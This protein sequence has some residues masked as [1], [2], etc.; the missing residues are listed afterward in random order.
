MWCLENRKL[1]SKAC[2]PRGRGSHQE[3]NLSPPSSSEPQRVPVIGQRPMCFCSEG[4]CLKSILHLRCMVDKGEPQE[5][6]SRVGGTGLGFDQ[7]QREE[8]P[9]LT[10]SPPEIT[11]L[12]GHPWR[13]SSLAVAFKPGLD[14]K[15]SFPLCS[16]KRQSRPDFWGIVA[17][18]LADISCVS[19]VQT[20]HLFYV[21]WVWRQG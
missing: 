16:G 10:F 13:L 8:M 6:P 2:G 19:L 3:S 12:N 15:V 20:F 5:W 4:G 14:L 18:M 1:V 11:G 9:D 21:L 17:L 7:G